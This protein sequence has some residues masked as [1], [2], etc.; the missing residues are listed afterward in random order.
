MIA[1]LWARRFNL[2]FRH[3]IQVVIGLLFGIVVAG[4]SHAATGKVHIAVAANFGGALKVIVKNF[5]EQS[6]YKVVVSMGSTGKLY[7]QIVQGAPYDLY[8]AA[9]KAR[10]EKLVEQNL[11]I[12][13]T[14]IRYATG[15]LALW[16]PGFN[17]QEIGLAQ[18]RDEAITKISVA[19]V[20][21]AP[22][23]LASLQVLD[24]DPQFERIKAK[25][26]YGESVAQA[27]HF[28]AAR[29]V[30]AGFVALSQLIEWGALRSEDLVNS[31][32]VWRVPQELYSPVEQYRVS[33][34]A[35]QDNPVASAF[36]E[37]LE[38]VEGQDIIKRFGYDI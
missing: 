6:G 1:I 3:L 8:F 9:D 32:S 5:E 30:H 15:I 36:I 16:A 29:Q 25:L 27:F 20:K 35:S 7:A 31:A 18:L 4:F 12:E 19:N 26:V 38:S 17:M 37:Y 13:N 10:P 23:G 34:K 21:T 11:T 22:Y 14:P 28:V 33:L 2:T 24:S